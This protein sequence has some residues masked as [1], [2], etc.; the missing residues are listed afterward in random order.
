[1][2]KKKQRGG[3]VV[4]LCQMATATSVAAVVRGKS[5]PPVLQQLHWETA[6][7]N[8]A[9]LDGVKSFVRQQKLQDL[10]AVAVLPPDSYE[11]MQIELA[12]LP[13]AERREAAR[14]Q[15]REMLEFPVDQA[16]VDIF[17]VAIFGSEKK[18]LT[19]AVAAQEKMLRERLELLEAADLSLQAIDV[20]EFALRNVAELFVEDER[21]TAVLLLLEQGGLFTI[22]RDGVHYLTRYLSSG[23]KDLL[24][25]ADGDFEALSEQLDAIVLEVQRTF[26]YCESTF[27]LPMVSRL[28]VAQT[29]RQIPAVINYFNDY[30]TTQV[31]A[32]SLDSVLTVPEGT[33]PLE[34]NKHL[35]AIGGALRQEDD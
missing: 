12:D 34:L 5:G 17:D 30:L 23:M 21:G 31:E 33:E 26:D 10:A 28:L 8:E 7:S 2:G 4:G 16:V 25:Y 3:A 14:W 6:E 19:Y 27:H 9:R 24:P 18:P 35:L 11:L 32:L 15:I 13:R 1:L 22:V 29:E 20:P